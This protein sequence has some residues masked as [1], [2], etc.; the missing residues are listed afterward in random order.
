MPGPT[1]F[2]QQSDG[3]Y[4]DQSTL[5]IDQRKSPGQSLSRQN[6]VADFNNDGRPDLLLQIMDTERIGDF[7]TAIF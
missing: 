5:F 3:T 7:V 6:L 1:L 4:L 2:L